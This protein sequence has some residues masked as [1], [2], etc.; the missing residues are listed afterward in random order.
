[1]NPLRKVNVGRW[2]MLRYYERRIKRIFKAEILKRWESMKD[3]QLA[4]KMIGGRSRELKIVIDFALN[5]YR[6]EHAGSKEKPETLSNDDLD[7]LAD[8]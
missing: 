3:D 5:Y 2:V 6:D 8:K 1:M 7:V 4:S